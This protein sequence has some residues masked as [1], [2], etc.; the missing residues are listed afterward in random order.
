MIE[1]DLTYWYVRGYACE[2]EVR[3]MDRE[4]LT[5]GQAAEYSGVSRV[6][7]WRMVK[8]GRLLAYQNPRDRRAKLVKRADLDAALRPVPLY[9]TTDGQGKAAA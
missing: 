7:I 6:T 4:Y 5:L 8:E 2:K 3:P 9:S 1:G